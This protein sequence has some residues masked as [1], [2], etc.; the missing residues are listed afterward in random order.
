MQVSSRTKKLIREAL[1]EDIGSGDVTTQVFVAPK[2]SGRAVL[3]AKGKGVLAGQAVFEEAF[4]AVNPKVRFR[5]FKKDGQTISHGK[6]ICEIKGSIASILE[7]ERTALN[8]ISHLSGIASAT[9][10]FVAKVRGTKAK[11]YDTRKTIPL[12]REIEKYA[13]KMGGGENHRM[14]LWDQGFVKDNH[15][16]F[17]ENIH[18]LKHKVKKLHRKNVVLEIEEKHLKDLKNILEAKPAVILLDNFSISN[19]KRAVKLIRQHSKSAIEVSGGVSHGNVGQIAK[20]GVDR[21]SV[22]SITHSPRAFDF[23]LEVVR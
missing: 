23:S 3:Y 9:N 8:F 22:G 19:I 11:I 2:V 16:H 15:W 18:D 10:Q 17:A 14:G 12:W 13:V 7:A 4:R 20:T 21:I 6:K 1:R 5:W